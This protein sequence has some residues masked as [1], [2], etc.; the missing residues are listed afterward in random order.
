MVIEPLAL[1][2]PDTGKALGNIGRSKVYEMIKAGE[3]ELLK[4]GGRSTVTM[5]SIRKRAEQVG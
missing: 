3:L 1:S 2:I 4:L 5:K